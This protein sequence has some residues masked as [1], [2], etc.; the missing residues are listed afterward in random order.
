LQLAASTGQLV[1]VK[2]L[3]EKYHC[4]DSLIAPDGQIA[5][6]LAAENGHREVVDYLPSRRGGGFRR[7]KHK[8]KT[9]IRRV[10]TAAAGIGAFVKFFIWDLEKFFLWSVPKHLIVQPLMK[11]SAWCWKHRRGLGPWCM[12]QIRETPARVVRFVKWF[13]KAIRETGKWLWSG[14]RGIP[15]MIKEISAWIWKLV[16]VKLPKTVALLA[17]WAAS[18]LTSV[19]K[20]A[21][22][23]I[24]RIVSFL[25]TVITAIVLFFQTLTLKDIWNGFCDALSAVFVSLPR[26]IWSWIRSFG[27]ASYKMM[28]LILGELGEILWYI[29][30]GIFLVVTFIPRKLWVI[31]QSLGDVI[32]KAAYEIRVWMDPKAR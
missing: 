2:L 13:G 10:K 6:R 19:A 7:W 22:N 29:G 5:L 11:A 26:L 24:L 32:A 9:A 30:Y 31:L 16:T 20:V 1:V 25:S 23:A 21:W 12:R 28:K 4:D 18:G 27:D 17:R 8:N 14:I 3:I 15:K